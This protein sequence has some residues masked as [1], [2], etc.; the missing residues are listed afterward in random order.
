MFCTDFWISRW[1]S[2]IFPSY[3]L[4]VSLFEAAA[5]VCL[6]RRRRRMWKT[7]MLGLCRCCYEDCWSLDMEFENTSRGGLSSTIGLVA[8][9]RK[10]K[11]GGGNFAHGPKFFI[12]TLIRQNNL[13]S[14]PTLYRMLSTHCPS[15]W[16]LETHRQFRFGI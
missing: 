3:Y 11:T 2:E 14:R 16:I 12:S 10:Q 8:E 5:I 9:N 7:N 4:G 13:H 15:R 1:V 6:P